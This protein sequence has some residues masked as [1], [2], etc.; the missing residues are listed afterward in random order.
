MSRGSSAINLTSVESEFELGR[1]IQ[2]LIRQGQSFSGHERHCAFLNT[3]ERRFADISAV[4]GMDFPDDGRAIAVV[5][6]DHDGD[7]DLWI[8]NRSGPQARFLRNNTP[9]DH[10]HLSVRLIGTISNRDAIGAR[11]ELHLKEQA[12]ENSRPAT[13]RSPLIKTVRAGDAFLAQSSKWVHFGLGDLTEID[14]LVVRW[15]SGNQEEFRGLKADG[16]YE[17]HEGSGQVRAWSQS[18]RIV[19]LKPSHLTA[20]Q[21]EELA[22]IRL[23]QR[24]PLPILRYTTLD[25]RDA[26]AADYLGQPVLLNLWASWCRPCVAELKE[27]VEHS[28]QIKAAGLT[29]V[30]LSVDGLDDDSDGSHQAALQMLSELKFPFPSGVATTQLVDILETVHNFIFDHYQE[31]PLP[32]SVL[33]DPRGTL[34]AIYKGPVPVER[35]LDD[36]KKLPLKDDPFGAKLLPLAGRSLVRPKMPE[37]VDFSRHL[38]SEGFKDEALDYVQRHEP[39]LIDFPEFRPLLVEFGVDWSIQGDSETAIALLLQALELDSELSEAHRNLGVVY[40]QL[41]EMDKSVRHLNEAIRID[42]KGVEAYSNLGRMLVNS[43]EAEKAGEHFQQALQLAP[44]NPTVHY[45]LG[46]WYETQG[47]VKEAIE[48]LREAIRIYPE[49]VNAQMFLGNILAKQ[50]RYDEALVYLRE[51]VRLLPDNA[52]TQFNLGVLLGILGEVAES[53]DHLRRAVAIRPDDEAAQSK[54][55]HS[56]C[57]LGNTVEGIGH[58]QKVLQLNPKNVD[59]HNKLGIALI[60]QGDVGKAVKNFQRAMAIAPNQPEGF[61]NLAKVQQ[62]QGRDEEATKLYE[63]VVRIYP[64]HAVAHNNLAVLLMSQ[65]RSEDAIEHC[66]TAL[67]INP[68]FVKARQNLHKWLGSESDTERDDE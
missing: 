45:D 65:G 16:R 39:F 29:V 50:N 42:P 18:P 47:R 10:H 30:A 67:Q 52:D 13:H 55:A 33:I 58:Y 9:T 7:L 38:F 62:S 63:R 20:P 64:E 3:T 34:A 44:H 35:L 25:G 51:S 8:A 15:P 32:T 24:I 41:G 4:S 37:L 19:D 28:A 61:F 36:V 11:V 17:V 49:Y 12:S 23:A 14:R 53:V 54:L 46:R 27:F 66:R 1:M 60:H 31:L 22:H 26:E 40:G 48:H 56:L 43:G 21:P 68:D 59:A 57:V 6:W 2:R 5:D